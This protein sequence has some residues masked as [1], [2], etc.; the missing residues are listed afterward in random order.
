M[1]HAAIKFLA[2]HRGR[3]GVFVVHDSHPMFETLSRLFPDDA[4]TLLLANDGASLAG[5]TVYSAF[6]I[7][8]PF[9]PTAASRAAPQDTTH[10]QRLAS[11]LRSGAIEVMLAIVQYCYA[12]ARLC[13]LLSRH[14]K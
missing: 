8:F 9:F 10:E 13:L 1:V 12:P 3:G 2:R 5:L 6:S 4:E 7:P 14:F 11:S